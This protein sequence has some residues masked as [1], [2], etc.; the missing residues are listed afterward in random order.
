M[1]RG[2]LDVFSEKC[3][4][5]RFHAHTHEEDLF[6]AQKVTRSFSRFASALTMAGAMSV[7]AKNKLTH[8]VTMLGDLLERGMSMF[9]LG[10][11]KPLVHGVTP[12]TK[13]HVKPLPHARIPVVK[14]S[15]DPSP[16]LLG[17]LR[18]ISVSRTDSDSKTYGC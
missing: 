10:L 18:V 5:A 7:A 3:L 13:L 17:A 1:D 4:T 11:L 9:L 16:G 8:L 12:E 2:L 14:L 15:L 6:E